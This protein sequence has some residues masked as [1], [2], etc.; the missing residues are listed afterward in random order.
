MCAPA[1]TPKVKFSGCWE[2]ASAAWPNRRQLTRARIANWELSATPSPLTVQ[3][4][5]DGRTRDLCLGFGRWGD[6]WRGFVFGRGERCE[7]IPNSVWFGECRLDY[8]ETHLKGWPWRLVFSRRVWC[9]F[10]GLTPDL[11]WFLSSELA[12]NVS[13]LRKAEF[14]YWRRNMFKE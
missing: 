2:R 13:G 14:A 8:P 7:M 9:A 5:N 6:L 10:L 4:P 12:L 3:G 11:K 1:C